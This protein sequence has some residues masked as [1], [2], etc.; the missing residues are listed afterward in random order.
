[1]LE[2]PIVP[3]AHVQTLVALSC[4]NSD[5]RNSSVLPL[6]FVKHYEIAVSEDVFCITRC[7]KERIF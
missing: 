5:M 2:T 7:G 4:P 3:E 1:M 6:P